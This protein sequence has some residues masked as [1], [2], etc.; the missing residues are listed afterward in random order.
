MLHSISSIEKNQKR[1]RSNILKSLKSEI[2]DIKSTI[3]NTKSD[4]ASI[5]NLL[6]KFKSISA[7]INESSIELLFIKNGKIGSYYAIWDE[8]ENQTL[9][10]K[11]EKRI[12]KKQ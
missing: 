2:S 4:D 11:N 7:L 5:Q 6:N 12:K 8:S 10:I 1:F 9:I 3:R